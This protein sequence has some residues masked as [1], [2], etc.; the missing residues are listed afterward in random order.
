MRVTCPAYLILLL[1]ILGEQYKLWSSSLCSFLRPPVT[2]SRFG[3]N[4]L[5]STLFSNTP[6]PCSSLNVRDQVSHPQLAHSNYTWRTVQVMKLL[7]MHFS[8][9]SCHFIPTDF[10]PIYEGSASSVPL[11]STYQAAW[12]Q[13]IRPR[14]ES[15]P[16]SRPEGLI[17]VFVLGSCCRLRYY[18]PRAAVPSCSYRCS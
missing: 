17:A 13:P 16:P 1:I 11:W 15:R 6:S 18:T 4:I 2:S 14:Y 7:I 5:L 3:P 9:T 10:Y 12:F 8:P